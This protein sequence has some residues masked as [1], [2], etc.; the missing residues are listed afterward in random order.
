VLARPLVVA[1]ERGVAVK[2]LASGVAYMGWLGERSDVDDLTFVEETLQRGAGLFPAIASLGVRHV[3]GGDYD[4]TPDR[5]P[6]IGELPGCERLFI[7]AG[8]SGHGFMVAPAAAEAV[9]R[10]VRGEPAP[11]PLDAF[12]PARFGREAS[13]ESLFI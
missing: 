12:S 6:L 2:Q 5:R 3:M 7:A 10:L 1:L 13:A 11:V 4:L 8:F 9:A